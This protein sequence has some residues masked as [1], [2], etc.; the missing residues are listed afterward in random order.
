MRIAH[1]IVGL[2]V[3]GA[4]MMLKRLV[5]ARA[6]D[7][8]CEQIVISLTDI[9]KVG[10]Q[11]QELGIEVQSLSMRSFLDIPRVLRA[12]ILTIRSLKPDVVQTWMYH[13]DLL[14]GLAARLAG[15]KNVIWGIRGTS[16]PQGMFSATGAVV[17]ACALLSWVVPRVIVCCAESARRSH[18]RKGFATGKMVVIPNGYDIFKFPPRE[19]GRCRIR[20]ELGIREH[21]LVVGIVGRSDPLKDHGNFLRAVATLLDAHPAVRVLMVGR[22]IESNAEVKQ[23]IA[24]HPF[25]P[26][27]II[28][29]GE[30]SDVP[31]CLSAM[32]VFC[33]SSKSEGFPNVVC[34]A[35]A[36]SL[37]CVVTDVGDA[38]AILGEAGVV[39]P[40]EDSAALARG[41]AQVLS[42]SEPARYLIGSAARK[43][44][45]ENFDISVAAKRFRDLQCLGER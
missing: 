28:F 41:L 1:I 44:V 34:E 3:G 42:V 35:M 15:V 30:R 19:E 8:N 14:G 36:M 13:A 2:N 21:E 23:I 39:V 20:A 40:A 4:E 25:K 31:H 9:G 18:K 37:P 45:V 22:D 16:I 33:L 5:V 7:G 26:G 29:A 17:G 27:Q 11:L 32:D 12:L 6:A 43:R 10:Q 24:E 38:R